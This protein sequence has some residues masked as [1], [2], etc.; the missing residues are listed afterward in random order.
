MVFCNTM[1]VWTEYIY[2]VFSVSTSETSS[3]DSVF[4]VC[5]LFFL[6]IL[7]YH[8]DCYFHLVLIRLFRLLSL[9]VSFIEI[10]CCFCFMTWQSNC[11]A[12]W[13]GCRCWGGGWRVW[14]CQFNSRMRFSARHRVANLLNQIPSSSWPCIKQTEKELM[15]LRKI[16]ITTNRT[17]NF[18]F[19]KF[20]FRENCWFFAFGVES[21]F[22]DV[23]DEQKE[24][25]Q[26]VDRLTS[27]T[28]QF[29][30]N[31]LRCIPVR[32]YRM[33]FTKEL[34]VLVR[35]FEMRRAMF[36][37]RLLE[38]MLLKLWRYSKA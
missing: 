21:S 3:I 28:L 15:K 32:R 14:W 34:T 9:Y 4:N 26:P 11:W 24:P 7:L 17:R 8:Q 6:S 37:G 25:V 31:A 20:I 12:I 33:T 38:R 18:S 1:T 22:W 10:L 35:M 36:V 23:N 19:T 30:A 16:R 27:V 13:G 2:D 5:C 29:D